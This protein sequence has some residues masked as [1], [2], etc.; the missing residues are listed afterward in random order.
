[1]LFKKKNKLANVFKLKDEKS[2]FDNFIQIWLYILKQSQKMNMNLPTPEIVKND[3]NEY[4][5]IWENDTQYFKIFY[6]NRS[7][8]WSHIKQ[9]GERGYG[10][11]PMSTD[12]Y[13]IIN[14]FE[15]N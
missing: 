13:D 8:T 7:L 12:I 11:F 14:S 1:M 4:V 9:N 15:S 2:Q 10:S 6:I 5:M 3:N